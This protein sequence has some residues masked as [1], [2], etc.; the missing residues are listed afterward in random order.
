[1]ERI[2]GKTL[3]GNIIRFRNPKKKGFRK[4]VCSSCGSTFFTK[5]E[6]TFCSLKCYNISITK[7]A[8]EEKIEALKREEEI[9]KQ[10]QKLDNFG[11]IDFVREKMG[12][13]KLKSGKIKCLK[14]DHVFS[15]P[16]VINVRLCDDCRYDNERL[17]SVFVRS[18]SVPNIKRG[19]FSL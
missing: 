11:N 7:K 12:M 9:R 3:F 8:E 16:D 18:Q 5:G 6:I 10:N 1:M 4:R 14:C 15:S 2:E 13:R 19:G 17:D